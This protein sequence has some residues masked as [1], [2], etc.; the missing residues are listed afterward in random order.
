MKEPLYVLDGYALIYRSYFAFLKNPL[1]NPDGENVSAV[2]GFFRTLLSLFDE[3][4]PKRYATVLD[5]KGPTFRH[6]MYA[7]YKATREKAPE[8]LHTQIPKLEEI[9]DALGLNSV[10]AQG[11]EADDIIATYAEMCVREG[12]MCYIVSGDKDL[13]QLVGENVRVLKPDRRGGYDEL[14]PESVYEA[15][16]VRPDQILDYLALIGDSSD[17]IPG[18]RG[19]GPKTAVKLLAEYGTID[20]VYTHLEECPASQSKKLMQ[21]RENAYL[22]RTLVTLDTAVPDIPEIDR[23]TCGSIDTAA[24]IPLFRREGMRSIVESL[25]PSGTVEM[26]RKT[27]G[28]SSTTTGGAKRLAGGQASSTGQASGREGRAARSGELA[29]DTAETGEYIAVTDLATLDEW[30]ETAASA[31]TVAFDVETDD[32]NEMQAR[33]VGFSIGLEGKRACY[34]PLVAG[35]ETVMPEDGVRERLRRLLEDPA[36]T[37]VGQNYKYDYKVLKR[38]GIETARIGFDTMIAAWLLDSTANS[39]NMD[40]LAY[41]EFGYTTIHYDQVVPKGSTFDDVPLDEATGYAAE[42]ADITYRLYSIYKERLAERGLETLYYETELPLVKVLSEME[43]AGIRLQDDVL[44]EYSAEL[45]EALAEIEAAVYEECGREFNLGS[46]KQLQEVLFEE[47]KLQPIKKT[48]TGYSTDSAVLEQL[49]REDPVPGMILDYRLKSKLKSTYVDALP[50]MIDPDTG[51]IHTRFVQTGTATGRLSSRDPNLQ[52]IPIRDEEGRRI[53][54]AFTAS[55]GQIFLSADYAQIE[56]VVLAHLSGDESL[57]NAFES[58]EDVHRHT[59]ALIFGVEPH[60]V[61]S[62]QRRIAKTINFGVMYG[63]SAFRLSNELK[64]PRTTAQEFIDAYFAKYRGVS[65]F[66]TRVKER[67]AA[68]GFVETILGRRRGIPGI[69]SRNKTQRA[70]AERIAVN[71]PIQGSAADIVKLAMLKIVD[72]LSREGLKT[73]LLLQVHDELI[74]EVPEGELEG[75]T[76]AVREEMETAVTLDVPLRVSIEAGRSWGEMH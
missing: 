72:R 59:G 23:L 50:R 5:S 6:E 24:A 46:T 68:D 27:S 56:L 30:I 11:F 69:D 70:A 47:R 71:T 18:V 34:I 45:T 63:M 39:F 75:V 8:D 1:F 4:G 22:S 40:A 37:I 19:I 44:R 28:P 33:P 32:L 17:N 7:E 41:R 25:D 49:A 66:I 65:A 9:H 62:E 16:G 64:I 31:G 12:R 20:G 13:L 29:F 52:N 67:A 38:W 60:E 15:W 14:G 21:G 53:R 74:F 48:K 57:K 26:N 2:F 54:T 42:D 58:G 76:G 51:R 36:I 73:R 10:R 43:L 35:G 3:Y 61:S 55:E